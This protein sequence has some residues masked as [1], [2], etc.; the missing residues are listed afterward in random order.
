[1]LNKEGGLPAIGPL[2]ETYEHVDFRNVYC[3]IVTDVNENGFEIQWIDN[4]DIEF[5]VS[6]P[7]DFIKHKDLNTGDVV[8]LIGER[9]DTVISLVDLTKIDSE[10][11]CIH[12]G[13]IRLK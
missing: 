8:I 11:F 9:N 10:D 4:P 5:E 7:P 13:N 2:Y 6:V 1:M 3:G 12:R